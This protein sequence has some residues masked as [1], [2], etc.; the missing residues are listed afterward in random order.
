[1]TPNLSTPAHAGAAAVAN[2]TLA[3]GQRHWKEGLAF[4][5]KRQWSR[6]AQ[7]FSRATQ[8]APHDALYWV[9]L[10]N[11]ERNAGAAERAEAAARHAL[12][13]QPGE[14]LA[15]QVLGDSLAQMHRYADS[16]E[17]FAQL[18]SQGTLEP[19]AMVRQ[20]SMLLS[21]QRPQ[22]AVDV[23]WRALGVQPGLVRG[24]AVLADAYRDM[25][26]KREAVECMKTVLALEP[27]RLEALS[28][29]SFEKRHL[30]D[31]ADFDTDLAAIESA[32]QALV[33]GRPQT[34]A[35]FGL[36]S[37]PL[38]PTLQ[39]RAAAAEALAAAVGVQPLPALTPA[40]RAERA[41][42]RPRIGWLSH[43]FREHPVSQLLVE[44]LEMID[45]Q[46][47]EV[48]LYSSGP[49]DGSPLRQRVVAAADRF[50]DIRG[51]SDQQAAQLIRD[52]GVDLLID[53]TGHTRGHRMGV[54]ARR[55][56]P[57]QLSFL[58]QVST[59]GADFIDYLIGDPLVTPLALA[60]DYSEQIAQ[61][62]LTLQPNGRWRPLPQPMT[63]AQAG[64]PEDAFVM[65]AFNHTYKILP[66]A[67]DRWCAVMREV[68]RA[69]LWLKETNGQLRENVLLEL[70]R[71]GVAA[72]RVVFARNV[73]YEDH[74]SRLA[75]A[76]VFVD[77][78]PYCAQTT[79]SDALWA[80]VP[81]LTL[82]GNAYASRVAASV[83]NAAGLGELA[84]GSADDY[85]AA[86]M[87]LALDPA[88]A[89]SYKQ[90][91]QSRRLALPLF[92]TAA[93]ARDFE[94]L[95]SR[96]WLRWCAGLPPQHLPAG[97]PGM[98]GSAPADPG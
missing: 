55:P 21:L 23:L 62:P 95:L 88:L 25:G 59:T 58:G 53:L 69:V 6:A 31:W 63:R 82:Y 48:L 26:F 67:M 75:L 24:H 19:E 1:M 33:P 61:M 15:L 17:V 68:P 89:A 7:S 77:T 16:V 66:E 12:A 91:L 9:N 96:M 49:D 10:A 5:K 27:G 81:V 47:F 35:S 64:L 74:F 80:G 22:E 93:Y 57:L 11:A 13:L 39:R 94:A 45:R 85:Q 2:R 54:F 20:A 70:A 8:A 34:C 79:A 78:W 43:D 87:A 32:L 14:P 73:A 30:C 71:R 65:C 90:L 83:L 36:L 56:A 40:Q 84:F 18:E 50:S 37:L 28:H 46:R 72:D 52:E 92:D 98:P 86:L 41:A 42:R 76:D 97:I 60:G 29:L 3:A 44:L 4:V 51:L 38:D